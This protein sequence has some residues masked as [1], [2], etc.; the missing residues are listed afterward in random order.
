[1]NKK[2]RWK[3][4]TEDFEDAVRHAGSLVVTCE[5]CDRTH[6]ATMEEGT[7]D[8]GELE[9]LRAKAAKEPD[10]YIEDPSYDSISWGTLDGRQAV[11]GC[12]CNGMAKYEDFIWKN[13][14][15]IAKYLK[16]KSERL[17]KSAADNANDM[18][19]IPEN[20]G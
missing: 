12:P 11:I 19:A 4:V 13:R 17:S 20:M 2:K 1:M 5:L 9:D 3:H 10:K 7:F 15:V 16:R 18:K 14:Y 8:R 6:F